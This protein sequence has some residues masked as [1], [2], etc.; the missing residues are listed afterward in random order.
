MTAEQ[1]ANW[2]RWIFTESYDDESNPVPSLLPFGSTLD[3][4]Y[5]SRLMGLDNDGEILNPSIGTGVGS[6]FKDLTD[7]NRASHL[8]VLSVQ[9]RTPAVDMYGLPTYCN[10]REVEEWAMDD[11]GWGV[12]VTQSG[13]CAITCNFCDTGDDSAETYWVEMAVHP[14]VHAALVAQTPK[15]D[16][17]R[18]VT[19]DAPSDKP[20]QMEK[21]VRAGM[22]DVFVSCGGTSC[23]RL[24]EDLCWSSQR[25]H[26]QRAQ[27]VC[28]DEY[29]SLPSAKL[30]WL[31]ASK[32]AEV[33]GVSLSRLGLTA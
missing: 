16:Q 17:W 6:H 3:N 21:I 22:K 10:E 23:G 26:S 13:N 31:V 24:M 32:L 27:F 2:P 29:A 33:L 12:L 7:D 5:R 25:G 30:Y 9:A 18:F 14:D 28:K 11:C 15:L 19:P 20:S 1:I 4:R 8:V